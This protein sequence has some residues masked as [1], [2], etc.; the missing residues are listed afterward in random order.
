[1]LNKQFIYN[2]EQL[3]GKKKVTITRVTFAAF[4]ILLFLFLGSIL[5]IALSESSNIAES[6]ATPPSG[7]LYRQGKTLMLNGQ[8]YKFTGFNLYGFAGCEGVTYSDADIDAYFSSLQPYSITRT[9]AFE[10]WG[11]ERLDAVVRSAEARNQLLI[12]TLADGRGHCNETDGRPGGDGSGKVASWYESGYRTRYIPWIQTVAARYKDSPAVGMLE[13]INEP[14]ADGVTDQEMKAFFDDAAANIKAIDPNHLVS[15]GAQAQYVSGTSDYA[16]VHSGPNIDVGT[17]HE[18]DYDYQDSNTI[19]SIHLNPTLNAM[20]SINKPLVIGE[21]GIMAANSNCRTSL[22]TR[23]NAFRQ[24]FDGYLAQG[25]AGVLMWNWSKRNL[26]SVCG[27]EIGSSDPV[28]EMTRSYPYPGIGTPTPTPTPTPT[29]T[30]TPT[31]TPVNNYLA[32]GSFENGLSPWNLS[33]TSPAVASLAQVSNTRVDGNFS[34]RVDVDRSSSNN[35]WHV[36]FRQDNLSLVAGRTYTVTFWAKASKNRQLQYVLQKSAS[37]YTVYS[38]QTINVTNAWKEFTSTYAATNTD[39][40]F[41]G[42]NLAQTNGRIWIDKVSI[43]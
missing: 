34:A 14:G 17:L 36:Q 9:W 18:Y 12:L 39:V 43:R 33:V 16:Y 27:F 35:S 28:N 26:T 10:S 23:S 29:I 31:P 20:N 41:F 1:M 15:S 4:G 25:A 32:N 40:V 13:L 11:F 3:Q 7:F 21:T 37:P 6:P 2:A 38:S 24:K 22:V 5:P 30:P 42:F 8:V 19:I